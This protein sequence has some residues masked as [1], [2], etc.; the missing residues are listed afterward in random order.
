MMIGAMAA[1]IVGFTNRESYDKV[2]AIRI[3]NIIKSKVMKK[4]G[5]TYQ[6]KNLKMKNRSERIQYQA[7][8]KNSHLILENVP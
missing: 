4:N 5:T 7:R 1:R 3:K 6:Y 8:L 2:D